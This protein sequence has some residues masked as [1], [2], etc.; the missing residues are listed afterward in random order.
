M[1]FFFRLSTDYDSS[2][3]AILLQRLKRA[4]VRMRIVSNQ[5]LL[6][7]SINWQVTVTLIRRKWLSKR[8]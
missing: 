6:I 2:R 5:R 4:E 7:Y 8:I 1:F 3:S